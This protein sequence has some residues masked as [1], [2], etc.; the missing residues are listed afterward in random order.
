MNNDVVVRFA[1]W[2]NRIL[3]QHDLSPVVAYNFNLYEH[4]SET[5][6]QLVGATSYDPT[7]EDWACNAYFSSGEDLF[8]LPHSLT[9]QDWEDA[10]RFA[11]RLIEDY[12]Q[13]STLPVPLMTCRAV[14]VGFVDGS[15]EIVYLRQ[16]A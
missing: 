5:A 3:D 10:Q 13:R 4:E 8:I 2:V 15:L 14:T 16:D 6:V 9:G 7:N 12:L 1:A 11:I